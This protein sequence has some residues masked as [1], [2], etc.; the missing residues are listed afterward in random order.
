MKHRCAILSLLP[1]LAA[2]AFGQ[3]IV[4]TSPSAGPNQSF[5]G[6]AT[7]PAPRFAP[8]PV[9]G[10]PYYG[11]EVSEHEQTLADGTHISRTTERQKT[12]RDSQ[13]R[14]RTERPIA[15]IARPS[16]P[17]PPTV[18]Q[19]VDPVAGYM[20][21]L[22]TERQVVHRVA[23]PP[24]PGGPQSANPPR[25]ANRAGV[26][27]ATAASGVL[28]GTLPAVEREAGLQRPQ[29]NTEALG[30]KTIEGVVAVGTRRT[31]VYPAGSEGNDTPFSVISETWWSSELQLTLLSTT[32]DPRSG[33]TTRRI[34]NLNTEEPDPALFTLPA[35]YTIVD[36]SSSFTIAWGA[37]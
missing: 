19:I 5:R 16:A 12:W 24:P 7:F 33:V 37:R 36:E 30:S 22:D 1:L 3:T 14:T 32:N 11:E 28:A 15:F 2:L 9:A 31:R 4:S 35:D 21:T 26:R 27:T 17:E 13:G 23:A 10:A 18:V 25:L 29:S 34:V 20:Y 6:S 8:R